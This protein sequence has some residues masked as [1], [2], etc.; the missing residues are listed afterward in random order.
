MIEF[1]AAHS[2]KIA[3]D[4][5]RVLS[6]E[7]RRQLVFDW[8]P[9]KPQGVIFVICVLTFRRGVIGSDPYLVLGGTKS[10]CNIGIARICSADSA[11]KPLSHSRDSLD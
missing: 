10:H 6:Q 8:S 7:R 9:G 11:K 4:L 5:A 1:F 2:E 3:E